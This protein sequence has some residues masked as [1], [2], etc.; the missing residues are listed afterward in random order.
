MAAKTAV[1]AKQQSDALAVQK[2][3]VK[4]EQAAAQADQVARHRT[5]MEQLSQIVSAQQAGLSAGG[6]DPGSGSGVSLA[7]GSTRS[8]FQE[9]A[10]EADAGARETALR[11]ANIVNI[12]RAQSLVPVYAGVTWASN[13]ASTWAASQ[14]GGK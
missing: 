6:L 11:D 3:Q 9:S 1:D 14:K 10:N 8:A 12:G 5:R 4:S 7:G 13:V 2:G